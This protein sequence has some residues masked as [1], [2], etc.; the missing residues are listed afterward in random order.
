MGIITCAR[1]INNAFFHC[2]KKGTGMRESR[3]GFDPYRI[4]EIVH[5]DEFPK[6]DRAALLHALRRG[7]WDNVVHILD[8]APELATTGDLKSVDDAEL[9]ELVDVTAAC[10]SKSASC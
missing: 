6:Y 7:D 4:Y 3:L 10:A 9:H 2:Y 5:C 1:R 8:V